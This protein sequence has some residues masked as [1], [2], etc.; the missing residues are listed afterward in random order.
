M[1]GF[2]GGAKSSEGAGAGGASSKKGGGAGDPAE[3]PGAGANPDAEENEDEENEQD[4]GGQPG[5]AKGNDEDGDDDMYD[6]QDGFENDWER[7]SVEAQ[8]WS[9]K[10]FDTPKFARHFAQFRDRAPRDLREMNQK[11]T[12][13]VELRNIRYRNH[14]DMNDIFFQFNFGWNFTLTRVRKVVKEDLPGMETKRGPQRVWVRKGTKGTTKLTSVRQRVRKGEEVEFDDSFSF[15]WHGS[16][17]DLYEKTLH[18][19]VW[20]WNRFQPNQFLASGEQTLKSMASGELNQEWDIITQI[21]KRGKRERV[22]VGRL[23]FQCAFQEVLTYEIK[24]QNWSALIDPWRLYSSKLDLEEPDENRE[25]SLLPY[26]TFSLHRPHGG[27]LSVFSKTRQTA[28]VARAIIARGAQK[29]VRIDLGVLPAMTFKGTR[30]QFESGVIYVDVLEKRAMWRSPRTL[31]RAIIPLKSVMESGSLSARLI[32]EK[33]ASFWTSAQSRC[34]PNILL[35]EPD[36]NRDILE[37]AHAGDVAAFTDEEGADTKEAGY[38]SGSVDV[39]VAADGASW[40]KFLPIGARS[41]RLWREYAQVGDLQPP[42]L[43]DYPPFLQTYL[44]VKVVEARDLISADEDTGLSDPYVTVSWADQTLR[45]RTIRETL[46]PVFNEELYFQVPAFEKTRI[47]EDELARFPMIRINVWDYDDTGS[48]D[49]LGTCLVYLHEI[50]GCP[51]GPSGGASGDSVAMPPLT[52]LK[53]RRRKYPEGALREKY[54]QTRVLK[55]ERELEGLPRGVDSFVRI[56]AFFRGPWGDIH[57]SRPRVR[58]ENGT[59]LL[60]LPNLKPMHER[61]MTTCFCFPI[62]VTKLRPEDSAQQ[63]NF[64][65]AGNRLVCK[66][67]LQGHK[68]QLF[69]K[70]DTRIKHAEQKRNMRGAIRA[71]MNQWE[72]EVGTRDFVATNQ[73]GEHCWLPTFLQPLTPPKPMIHPE[74]LPYLILVSSQ[75]PRSCFHSAQLV[76]SMEFED[77]TDNLDSTL[78]DSSTWVS[79]DFFLNMRKGDGKAHVLLCANLFLG[80]MT[81]AYVCLGWGYQGLSEDAIHEIDDRV[82]NKQLTK[83]EG[84]RLKRQNR[85]EKQAAVWIMTR[86]SM[87]TS[88]HHR[89]DKLAHGG[90]V[91]FWDITSGA[92]YAALPSRWAG[93][94]DA[95]VLRRVQGEATRKKA[96]VG[97]GSKP[98]R[99][100]EEDGDGGAG[101]YYDDPRVARPPPAEEELL[102]DDPRFA[103]EV[104]VHVDDVYALGAGIGSEWGRPAATWHADEVDAWDEDAERAGAMAAATGDL[105]LEDEKNE[106]QW[107]DKRNDLLRAMKRAIAQSAGDAPKLPFSEI[108]AVFNHKNIWA[109]VQET[110]D[111]QRVHYNL[112]DSSGWV[113]V[114][115]A[116]NMDYVSPHY[117]ARNLSPKLTEEKVAVLQRE[118]LDEL[119]AGLEN[120]RSSHNVETHFGPPSLS[121]LIS[122]VLEARHHLEMMDRVQENGWERTE[123]GG[124][125]KRNKPGGMAENRYKSLLRSLK[126][127]T[128]LDFNFR[129]GFAKVNSSDPREIRK[130]LLNHHWGTTDTSIHEE[131]HQGR[132]MF[133][134]GVKVVPFYNYTCVVHVGIMCV[135]PADQP[136]S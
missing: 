84:R 49:L 125:W 70:F 81:D 65:L 59:N 63:A 115:D 93:Q 68:C 74:E 16:Y 55:L 4:G 39:D 124:A 94:D 131:S 128:P 42:E 126:M 72:A 34:L 83:E 102:E 130:S 129:I 21:K 31:G 24:L 51:R 54:I 101:H 133:A 56:E 120:F 64:E 57:E 1:L 19:E 60:L 112:E 87:S 62:G 69:A 116:D 136:A 9:E 27:R 61:S 132:E 48:S 35:P 36:V 15:K 98:A 66:R 119:E 80:L 58:A 7:Y 106:A 28:S 135:Y 109:N 67:S 18:I 89:L 127:T 75:K 76:R 17:F 45:T 43:R 123:Y 20:D 37:Q 85:G 32:A 14:A 47:R 12:W 122:K 53:I 110:T 73:Y 90:A 26:A 105:A 10:V 2:G 97:G 111:V 13:H 11:R 71:R 41:S 30:L 46:N 86:E 134:I 5:G 104:V 50:T 91:K 95:E 25:I 52:R 79:P 92:Y 6:A 23:V 107:K 8:N 77:F 114:L 29:R 100:K 82:R 117:S 33:R 118:I 38:V 99:A 78:I 22:A 121:K 96:K 103:P 108:I 3:D 40:S 88:A 113:P 44:C